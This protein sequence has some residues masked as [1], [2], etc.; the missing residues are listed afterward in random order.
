MTELHVSRE[1]I[2]AL[3]QTVDTTT[4]PERTKAVLSAIVSAFGAVV[5][6]DS[7]PAATLQ[8]TVR[9]GTDLEEEFATAFT[10]DSAHAA[11]SGVHVHVAF[12]KIGR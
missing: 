4:L 6:D 10:A 12:S 5:D 7:D 2:E 11:G 3:A 8:V 9:I 1:D